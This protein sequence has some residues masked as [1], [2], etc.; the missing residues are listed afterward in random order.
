MQD[1][2]RHRSWHM[3]WLSFGLSVAGCTHDHA[4]SNE[5]GPG[6]HGHDDHGQGGAA[7]D[8]HGHGHG[9]EGASEVVTLWGARTQLF[10]EFPALVVGEDS[11]FAAHL[12]RLQDHFAIDGG[13]VTVELSGGDLPV[14]RFAVEGPTVAGIFRPIA[15]PAQPGQRL[16]TLRL[17]SSAASESHEMGEFTVYGSREAADAAAPAEVEDGSIS[18]LLEQQW[19]VPFRVERIEARPMRPQIPAFAE[20]AV[21]QDAV[22]MVA[23]PRSGRLTPAAGRYP[24]VGEH[25]D[26][27]APLFALTAAPQQ[28]VDPAVLELDID[29]AAISVQAARR[30][31]NRLT[32]LVEQGVVAR[33][34]LDAAKTMLE[35]AQAELQ[36]ARRRKSN[37]AGAQ[38]LDGDTDRLDVPSPISGSLTELFAVS[39]AWVA[40]GERLARIVDRDRLWLD[41][42]VP[43]AYV[44]RLGDI[45][46]AWFQLA[47][48][49]GAGGAAGADSIFEVGRDALLLLGA[50]VDADK[51]TLLVRFA[52][53]NA[54]RELFAG[55]KILAHLVVDAPKLT[56][57]VPTDAVVDDSGTDVIYV[58]TGGESFE[59][60]VVTL[61]IRDG[62]Y[63]ELLKGAVPGEWVVS[64]GAWSVKLA[65][66]STE[67]I[68]HGHAH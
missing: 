28:N 17:D 62:S 10:V 22:A 58:Q 7:G 63:V 9:H 66:G 24:L 3:A 25:I 65:S 5:P 53:D 36:N 51:R 49:A 40:E 12:T 54:R 29:R 8:D 21:P 38:R 33:R 31:V 1:S 2:C 44:G 4:H 30:E 56:A 59:R 45:S 15:H 19:K 68:G 27:G 55:T 18:Y 32:P 43:E 57:A 48:A 37:L 50:E 61:G 47:G 41:V 6:E 23:A 13:T 26:A 46:G 60:R 16:V 11:P 39:G 34:R 35:T 64:R 20:L 67:A 42:G 14:E 52:L